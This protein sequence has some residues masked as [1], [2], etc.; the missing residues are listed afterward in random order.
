MKRASFIALFVTV[1]FLLPALIHVGDPMIVESSGITPMRNTSIN[2]EGGTL[3]S[4]SGAA[5]TATLKGLTKN[6]TAGPLHIDSSSSGFGSVELPVGWTGTNLRIDIPHSSMWV[7]RDP[8]NNDLDD[9]HTERWLD[10]GYDTST[11]QVPDD[12]TLVKQ[13]T[14]GSSHPEHGTFEMND[15]SNGVGGSKGWRFDAEY[16]AGTTLASTDEI[17][18]SQMI[19]IPR[20]ALYSVHITFLYNVTAN[21][22]LQNQTYVFVRFGDYETKLYVHE[23]GRTRNAWL[24]GDVVIPWSAY[25]NITTPE[26][27]PFDIGIGTDL[28]GSQASGYNS[29]TYIDE[30]YID[31]EVSPFSEQVNLK[32]NNTAVGGMTSGSV[33]PYVPDGANR[34]CTNDPSAGIDLTGFFND[35]RLSVAATG[36]GYDS[37]EAG[38]QFPLSIPQGAIITSAYMEVESATTTSNYVDMRL[39]A[40]DEDTV[41]A[42]STGEI[43]DDL[44]DWV[45]TSV[46]WDVTGW[47]ADTRYSSPDIT[48]LVQKVI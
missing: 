45:N 47:A 37:W 16:S 35:G 3:Y 40:S 1:L 26:S 21:T 39:Y 11:L 43:L 12:W 23:S 15:D 18:F 28:S 2:A 7:D 41:T 25:E 17:Y 30:V 29:Y 48:R 42:F 9:Y 32:A 46:D 8:I 24:V 22:N 4:G 5:R 14:S 33:S 13:E 19:N 34:D 38:F 44:F 31:F 6:E 36:S 20:R 27:L 10:V